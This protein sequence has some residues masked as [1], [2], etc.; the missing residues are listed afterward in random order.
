MMKRHFWL[1]NGG[2]AI[3]ITTVLKVMQEKM[4]QHL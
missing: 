1:E 3:S 4:F 2:N